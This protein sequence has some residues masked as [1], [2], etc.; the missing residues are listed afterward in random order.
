MHGNTNRRNMSGAF[1]GPKVDQTQKICHFKVVRELVMML[2]G[3]CC[4]NLWCGKISI[5]SMMIWQDYHGP[6]TSSGKLNRTHA[7]LWIFPSH[8]QQLVGCCNTV[9]IYLRSCWKQTN[10]CRLSLGSHMI[11]PSGGT[12]PPLDI[13]YQGRGSSIW[14]PFMQL[15]ILMDQH[16]WR[17]HL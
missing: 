17:R 2:G 1:I 15:R 8:E 13:R 6:R 10:P 14:S 9:S 4:P 11:L 7:S 16:F 12:I 3:M 5:S